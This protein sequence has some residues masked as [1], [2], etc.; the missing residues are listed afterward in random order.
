M[1]LLK[2][3]LVAAILL[4]AA[5]MLYDWRSNAGA[6]KLAAGGSPPAPP[7]TPEIAPGDEDG[8]ELA[9]DLAP[10]AFYRW[11]DER[12]TVHFTNELDRIPPRYRDVARLV[13]LPDVTVLDPNSV[14]A[15]FRG[16]AP[17][18]AEEAPA[19]FVQRSRR[20]TLYATPWCPHCGKARQ[21][22]TQLKTEFTELNVE[23]DA[24]AMRSLI[25]IVGNQP[26][27]PV[28]VI[29]GTPIVGYRPEAIGKALREFQA[30]Q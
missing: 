24:R 5:W 21:L 19:P 27:I 20:V 10:Q 26:Q 22:L 6:A 29:D 3:A 7:E 15:M 1:Q 13:D 12:G 8:S 17:P 2:L 23:S 14:A 30:R 28:T 9:A 25:E 16:E 4:V 11:T 18:P